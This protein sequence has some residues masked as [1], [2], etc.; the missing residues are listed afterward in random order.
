MPGAV[1]GAASDPSAI[2]AQGDGHSGLHG[3][4]IDPN[5]HVEAIG[6]V[7]RYYGLLRWDEHRLRPAGRILV[8]RED[9]TFLVEGAHG[10][11]VGVSSLIKGANGRDRRARQGAEPHRAVAAGYARAVA[12]VCQR[13]DV[14]AEGGRELQTAAAPVIAWC[15]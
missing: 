11:V 4:G 14:G 13:L 3:A 5:D 8:R 12:E 1:G 10:D 9:E 7:V 2:V 6:H 15:V